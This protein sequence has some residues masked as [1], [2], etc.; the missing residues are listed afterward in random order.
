ML[1]TYLRLF[2]F[3]LPYKWR[4]VAAFAC[5]IV[6]AA[7]TSAYAVLLGPALSFIFRGDVGS[8][9]DLGRFVPKSVDL[10]AWLAHASKTQILAFLPIL[11]MGVSL[12][13][14]FAYFGQAFLM[15]AVSS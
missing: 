6:L 8:A 9:A 14:G 7:A 11:V 12:V 4:F 1:R 5:M 3:A 13:K 2:R 10:T 15:S